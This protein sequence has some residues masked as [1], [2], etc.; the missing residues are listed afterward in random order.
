[1]SLSQAE[2]ILAKPEF[3]SRYSAKREMLCKDKNLQSMYDR[4]LEQQDLSLEAQFN[5]MFSIDG[6]VAKLT[7]VGG[8]SEQ[9][10]DWI[11]LYLGYGGVS[12]A[13][14][15]RAIDEAIGAKVERIDI[16]MNTG[17][18][19]IDYLEETAD[20]IKEAVTLGIQVDVY[21]GGMIASAGVWLAAP[22][23]NIYGVGKTSTIGSIGV[24]VEGYDFSEYYK[25][26]GIESVTIVNT[27]SPNK[28][29]DLTNDADKA[30]LRKELDDIAGIFFEHVA[31]ERKISVESLKELKGTMIISADA[32]AIGLMDS[33]KT[34]DRLHGSKNKLNLNK[35]KTE[36]KMDEEL[37]KN[38]VAS[39][40]TAVAEAV[41]PLNEKLGALETSIAADKEAVENE[42][43]ITGSFASLSTKY[44]EQSAMINEEMKKG[45]MCSSDFALSV[46]EAES[47]RKAE[48]EKLEA[49][50]DKNVEGVGA[51]KDA[52]KKSGNLDGVAKLFK[53]SK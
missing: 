21:N 14:I 28:R 11:D 33:Q 8:M 15:R 44:P 52:D 50:E 43:K 32:E 38:L 3:I 9:G 1:M 37:M 46:V 34:T 35:K 45:E 2:I 36:N 25:R 20:K 6:K 31:S 39:I 48:A 51:K 13:N 41:K 53:G 49:N 29:L 10:P 30:I 42:K 23:S 17:G 22:A 40:G 7:I 4:V 12:Y 19:N 5:K 47:A 26:M 27:D 18:G 16:A 24:V